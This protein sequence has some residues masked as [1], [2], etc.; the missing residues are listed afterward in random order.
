MLVAFS[1]ELFQQ[2]VRAS[3]F[4][5]Q[6]CLERPAGGSLKWRGSRRHALACWTDRERQRRRLCQAPI[7]STPFRCYVFN[8][9]T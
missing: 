4:P 3:P 8:R 5:Y 2:L 1:W 7:F 6:V 9:L